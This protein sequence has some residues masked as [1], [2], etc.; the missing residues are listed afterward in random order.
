M[1]VLY[2]IT[3][4]PLSEE[5]RT[6]DLGLLSSFYADDAAFNG[7]ARQSAQL[8]NLLIKRGPDQGY[9]PEPA[10]SLFIWTPRTRR[11]GEDVIC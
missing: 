8:L 6:A 3:L 7:S 9:F 1:M 5:L 10:K 11:G 4:V 2:M